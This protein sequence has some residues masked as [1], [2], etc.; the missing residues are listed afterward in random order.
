VNIGEALVVC[1]VLI[2][3]VFRP[4][5]RKFVLWGAALCLLRAVIRWARS[6][7]LSHRER[8]ESAKHHAAVDACIKRLTAPDTPSAD[9]LDYVNACEKNPET[10]QAMPDYQKIACEN[11]ATDAACKN[12]SSVI[13]IRGGE[14]LKYIPAKNLPKKSQKQSGEVSLDSGFVPIVYLG[15]KQTFALHCGVFGE[16]DERPTVKD[17]TVTCP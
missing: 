2:L 8:V 1:T 16:R 6:S 11:G 5:F 4:D 14:T 13:E 17:S 10:A 7:Y 15:H 9:S 12:Y 3:A